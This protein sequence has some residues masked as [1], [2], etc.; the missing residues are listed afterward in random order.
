MEDKWGCIL[1]FDGASMWIKLS[2]VDF[3]VTNNGRH[4]GQLKSLNCFMLEYGTMVKV[5]TRDEMVIYRVKY[6]FQDLNLHEGKNFEFE[7]RKGEL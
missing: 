1:Q 7:C 5:L 4:V 3:L 2:R 6:V